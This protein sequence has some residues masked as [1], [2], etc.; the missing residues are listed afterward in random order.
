TTSASV[1]LAEETPD[2]STIPHLEALLQNQRDGLDDEQFEG[3][4]R[5]RSNRISKWLRRSS[6]APVPI[7]PASA[8]ANMMSFAPPPEDPGRKGGKKKGKKAV[9][10]E[11]MP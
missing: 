9:R 1:A 2:L 5:R 11:T 3:E 8:P 4:V 6:T 7:T 10:R